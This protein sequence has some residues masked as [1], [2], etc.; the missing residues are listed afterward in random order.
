LHNKLFNA[1]PVSLLSEK[2]YSI[3][4]LMYFSG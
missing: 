3:E 2:H 1:S 4:T